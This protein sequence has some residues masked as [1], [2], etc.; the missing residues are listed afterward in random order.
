MNQSQH[1]PSELLYELNRITTLVGLAILTY[2]QP[3]KQMAIHL[4]LDKCS[5]SGKNETVVIQEL[6]FEY[7]KD[8]FFLNRLGCFWRETAKPPREAYQNDN[9]LDR[10]AQSQN[11]LFTKFCTDIGQ[12]MEASMKLKELVPTGYANIVPIVYSFELDPKLLI[13]VDRPAWTEQYIPT[14]QQQLA[15]KIK[16][17]MNNLQNDYVS[18]MGLMHESGE[19]LVESVIRFFEFLG[20]T[21]NKTEKAHPVD[22]K[23][24][25]SNLE[26]A[27]EVT[28]INSAVTH[29]EGKVTQV[30]SYVG[31]K[32]DSEKIILVANTFRDREPKSRPTESFSQQTIKILQPFGVCLVT[33]FNLYKLWCKIQAKQ[34]TIK[35]AS[36]LLNQTVGLLEVDKIDSSIVNQSPVHNEVRG[37]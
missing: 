14:L 36:D 10:W 24:I 34:L 32:A 20:F 1:A 30:I 31:D 17:D 29:K 15:S 4:R 13:C 8:C 28:G 37:V 16:E 12:I 23:A 25:K 21:A 2:D 9:I 26:F 22:I 33:S 6:G 27:I 5:L 35:Q 18:F 7:H 19:K 11:Y 3:N